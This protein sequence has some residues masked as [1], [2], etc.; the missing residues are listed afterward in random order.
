MGEQ[1]T[2]K[3]RK[4][5]SAKR[6]Q[7]GKYLPVHGVHSARLDK[8]YV[9]GRYRP[10]KALN[11]Y[12]RDLANDAGGFAALDAAQ[13]GMLGNIRLT[14]ATLMQIADY[15]GGLET[16]IVDGCLIPIV[17]KGQSTYQRDLQRFLCEFRETYKN[18]KGS[19]LDREK[20]LKSVSRD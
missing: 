1:G 18:G 13:R 14:M 19:R 8:R 4:R 16:I 5:R 11:K 17:G 15:T 12:I 10:A 9:D 6:D 7:T 3:R 20:W 2:E